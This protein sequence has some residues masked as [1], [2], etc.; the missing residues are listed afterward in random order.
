MEK[1]IELEVA[2]ERL[3]QLMK[4]LQS[5]ERAYDEALTHASNYMGN[6][7]RIEQVRDDRAMEVY[8]NLQRVKVEIAA[9]IQLVAKLASNY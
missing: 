3:S 6:D 4:E 5:L 8:Q 7:E 2:N 9:Q 1:S